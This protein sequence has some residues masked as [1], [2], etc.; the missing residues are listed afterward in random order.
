MVLVLKV[1]TFASTSSAS[2]AKSTSARRMPIRRRHRKGPIYSR[3]RAPRW[4]ALTRS[5]SCRM[6]GSRESDKRQLIFPNEKR[7]VISR[8]LPRLWITSQGR[9]GHLR[10]E[11]CDGGLHGGGCGRRVGRGD[12]ADREVQVRVQPREER[13]QEPRQERATEGGPLHGVD[14]RDAGEQSASSE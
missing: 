1:A 6:T 4:S 8:A 5:A 2:G 7:P 10:V 3:S 9:V 12:A 14:V 13:G 11:R